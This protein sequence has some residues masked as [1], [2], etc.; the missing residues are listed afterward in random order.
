MLRFFRPS[1]RLLLR[2]PS[3]ITPAVDGASFLHYP[4]KEIPGGQTIWRCLSYS[5][6]QSAIG[7]PFLPDDQPE[8][9]RQN[10]AGQWKGTVFKMFESAVTTL[11]SVTVL[12]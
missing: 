5:A 10:D 12:G 6:R 4:I 3:L 8:D 9:G 1:P 11:A 7:S 2:R